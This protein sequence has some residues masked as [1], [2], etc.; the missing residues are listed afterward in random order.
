LARRVPSTQA[1]IEF[2]AAKEPNKTLDLTAVKSV[3]FISHKLT[4]AP[5]LLS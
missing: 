4:G 1:V 2:D 5:P 3:V